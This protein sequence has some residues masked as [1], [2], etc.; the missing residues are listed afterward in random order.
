[1]KLDFSFSIKLDVCD[2]RPILTPDTCE[3]P[4]SEAKPII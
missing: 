1:M 2:Q 3:I 4:I